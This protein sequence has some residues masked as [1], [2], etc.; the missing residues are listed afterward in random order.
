VQ[1][2]DWVSQTLRNSK[3]DLIQ[4]NTR[5]RGTGKANASRHAL[6]SQ[7][8]KPSNSEVLHRIGS[9]TAGLEFRPTTN[10]ILESNAIL[11]LSQ[12]DKLT[13]LASKLLWRF[14]LQQTWEAHS[15]FQAYDPSW[16]SLPIKMPCT[17]ATRSGPLLKSID[18]NNLPQAWIHYAWSIINLFGLII[19]AW[20]KSLLAVDH[21]SI[22]AS[23]L[24]P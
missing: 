6:L 10:V 16:K 18:R 17:L 2:S 8:T 7:N 21:C 5:K 15:H 1:S 22:V 12:P 4:R 20:P 13:G 14:E 3:G 24:Q 11:S 23:I 19:L 9:F